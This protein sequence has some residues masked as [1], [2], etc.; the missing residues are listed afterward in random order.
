MQHLVNKIDGSRAT[1]YDISY[2]KSGYPLFLVYENGKWLRRSAKHY[3]PYSD[4]QKAEEEKNFWED[5]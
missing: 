3:M 5:V 2:D 4:W 1:V